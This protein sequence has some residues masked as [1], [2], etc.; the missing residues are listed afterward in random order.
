MGLSPVSRRPCFSLRWLGLS[1]RNIQGTRAGSI[2]GMLSLWGS[3][4][5]AAVEKNQ[6]PNLLLFVFA[7]LVS[8]DRALGTT[9][10]STSPYGFPCVPIATEPGDKGGSVPS[11]TT[12]LC[13]NRHLNTGEKFSCLI[14][15]LFCHLRHPCLSERFPWGQLAW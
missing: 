12:M 10:Y 9:C 3:E 2:S 5:I 11:P 6:F 13:F 7:W 1:W 8:C 14:P 4:W 15:V